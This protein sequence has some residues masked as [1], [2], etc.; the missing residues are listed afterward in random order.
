MRLTHAD[1]RRRLAE[2]LQEL[3]GARRTLEREG[4]KLEDACSHI[5]TAE[6]T[7]KPEMKPALK[8]IAFLQEH[9]VKCAL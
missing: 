2:V 5:S 1:S 9:T 7:G 6:A 3:Q 4:Q 8:V